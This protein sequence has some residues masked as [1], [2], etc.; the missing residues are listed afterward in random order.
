LGLKLATTTWG[1]KTIVGRMYGPYSESKTLTT[2][3]KKLGIKD[4][5]QSP[6]PPNLCKRKVPRHVCQ[7]IIGRPRASA[8]PVHEKLYV[9]DTGNRRILVAELSYAAEEEVALP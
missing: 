9:A 4:L 2:L 6:S 7:S 5:K 3:M 1:T 8:D